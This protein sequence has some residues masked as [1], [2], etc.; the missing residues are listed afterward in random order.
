MEERE[1]NEVK[2]PKFDVEE[3]REGAPFAVLSYVF[4]GWILTYILKKDNRFAIFHAR[5]G[6][7]ISV[8]SLLCFT[9]MFIPVLGLLFGIFALGLAFASLYGIYLS[10]TGKCERMYLISDV[11]DKLVV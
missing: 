10:L 4:F 11:A 2:T 9:I 7:V 6:I 1:S 5:Q 8:G 3:I